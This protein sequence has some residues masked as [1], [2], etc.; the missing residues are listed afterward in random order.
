MSCVLCT[1]P[2]M[3]TLFF[4]F[5]VSSGKRRNDYFLIIS[6]SVGACVMIS[7]SRRWRDSAWI[8]GELDCRSLILRS[9][10]QNATSVQKPLKGQNLDKPTCKPHRNISKVQDS[11]QVQKMSTTGGKWCQLTDG[12][13][14]FPVKNIDIFSPLYNNL[15]RKE[16]SLGAKL[17]G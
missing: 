9:S 17:I 8:L 7:P 2:L 15:L 5:C 16:V 4:F 11:W 3:T 6:L 12:E 1:M 14:K 10:V 13:E